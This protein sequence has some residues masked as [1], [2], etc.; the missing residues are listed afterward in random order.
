VT[1]HTEDSFDV[2]NLKHN[3]SQGQLRILIHWFETSTRESLFSRDM[4][5]ITVPS[6][7]ISGYED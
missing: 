3:L 5:N 6:Q 7:Y 4:F 2:L 1:N